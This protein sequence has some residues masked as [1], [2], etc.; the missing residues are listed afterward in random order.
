MASASAKNRDSETNFT[1][2]TGLLCSPHRAAC[3]YNT[4]DVCTS[5]DTGTIPATNAGTDPA[6]NAATN[7]ATNTATDDTAFNTAA[8]NNSRASNS[9]QR[10][11]V[12]RR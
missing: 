11:A 9:L 7:T 4:S 1:S 12:H 5:T 2:T 10:A 6:T 3:N 8:G